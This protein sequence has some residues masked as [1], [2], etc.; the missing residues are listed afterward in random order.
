MMM[1]L[2][3]QYAHLLSGLTCSEAS[4]RA[5]VQ[6]IRQL[7]SEEEAVAFFKKATRP[8]SIGRWFFYPEDAKR[9]A[10]RELQDYSKEIGVKFPAPNKSVQRFLDGGKD[11]AKKEP[12][13]KR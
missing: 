7:S 6:K 10:I 13:Q 8:R 2:V 4:N 1:D 9:K 3:D 5:I 11:S 12:R